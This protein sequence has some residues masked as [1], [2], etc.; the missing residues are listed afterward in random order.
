MLPAFESKMKIP[1]VFY[2]FH[3]SFHFTRNI[4]YAFTLTESD[5]FMYG[6]VV[7]D[8]NSVR[9]VAMVMEGEVESD[10]DTVTRIMILMISTRNTA[11]VVTMRLLINHLAGSLDTWSAPSSTCKELFSPS[12]R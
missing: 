4:S 5:V 10:R 11:I 9:P 1:Q 3:N 7:G 2:S 12:S 6:T 8:V